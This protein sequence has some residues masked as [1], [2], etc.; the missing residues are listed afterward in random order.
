MS[1]NICFNWTELDFWVFLDDK[2]GW[3][4]AICLMSYNVECKRI[5]GIHIFNYNHY[6]IVVNKFF[7]FSQHNPTLWRS[8][9]LC[10]EKG[11][12]DCR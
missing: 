6:S 10:C 9:G 2:V 12:C 11:K 8:Y 5:N 4:F 7:D 1:V 3:L